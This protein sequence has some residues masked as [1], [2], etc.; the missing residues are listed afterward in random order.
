[1]T[2]NCIIVTKNSLLNQISFLFSGF[3]NQ[4]PVLQATDVASQAPLH[5]PFQFEGNMSHNL[6]H[7]TPLT[8][9]TAL[10]APIHVREG[11]RGASTLIALH[12]ASQHIPAKGLE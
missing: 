10:Q 8:F 11:N 3:L 7:A 2:V 12:I 1:M 5:F 6:P 4:I 9:P